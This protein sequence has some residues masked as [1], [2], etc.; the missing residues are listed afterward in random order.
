MQ[1]NWLRL[2]YRE[3]RTIYGRN[4]TKLG[5]SVID[6]ALQGYK[7]NESRKT[8]PE[9]DGKFR[10]FAKAQILLFLFAGHDTTSSALCSIYHLLSTHST[11]LG[12][13]RAEHDSVFGRDVSNLPSLISEQS[14]PLKELPY[15]LAIIKESM[16]LFSPVRLH[17]AKAS[18]ASTSPMIKETSIR[19]WA[20]WSGPS[21]E[22]CSVI[23]R[24]GSSLTNS[25]L[26]A[27]SWGQ[28]IHFTRSKAPSAHLNMD[29][30][31]VS[32]RAW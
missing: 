22:P 14:H 20:S 23:Q 3:H 19:P 32:G 31:T 18:M 17:P 27:G 25:Y 9:M 13:L 28:K 6:L 7:A 15:T 11:A 10:A 8:T 12:R 5:N 21:T 2:N 29:L 26:T 1:S 16:R 4:G 24:T 30:G